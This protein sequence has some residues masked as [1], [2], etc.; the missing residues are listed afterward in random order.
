MRDTLKDGFFLAS[1]GTFL[2]LALLHPSSI[3]SLPDSVHWETIFTLAGLLL[4]TTAMEESGFFIS[5]SRKLAFK[6][7]RERN[8]ALFLV[9]LSAL[10]STF[11]TNDV[12]LFVVVPITLSLGKQLENDMGKL[13]IFEAMAVNAGSFLTPIGNPQNIFLW[14]RWNIPFWKFVAKMAPAWAIT[15]ALLLIFTFF[16]FGK[17]IIEAKTGKNIR[18]V[19]GKL[20]A[21]SAALM[22]FFLLAVEKDL[23]YYALVAVV[24]LYAAVFP[25][26]LARTNWLLIV[27]FVVLFMDV[28]LLCET[29]PLE[30]LLETHF[31]RGTGET[32]LSAI[33]LSQLISNVPAAILLGKVSSA[34]KAIAYGVNIGGNGLVIASL[35]NVLALNLGGLRK[36]YLRFQAYS[37][38]FLLVSSAAVF[39][40]LN[41]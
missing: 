29:F 3:L 9:V 24:L 7:H 35:A 1:L 20:L 33:V 27:L 40:L 6:F 21:L 25:K 26:I 18:R 41:L 4:I 5:L 12:T 8:L 34:W 11:L 22:V 23:T 31:L 13:V 14:H 32:Y 39:L 19:N 38:P 36:A 17:G 37:L 15:L 30:H 10:L 16:A 28:H 2:V